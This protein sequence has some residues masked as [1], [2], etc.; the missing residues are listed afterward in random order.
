MCLFAKFTA[1][2]KMHRFLIIRSAFH[3]SGLKTYCFYSCGISYSYFSC[4]TSKC[5]LK[6]SLTYLLIS[7]LAISPHQEIL[8][9]S[10]LFLPSSS[11]C[12]RTTSLHLNTGILYCYLKRPCITRVPDLQV[13]TLL[14]MAT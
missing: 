7:S 12:S 3:L 5:C 10:V 13:C 11:L 4:I 14:Y 2:R 9:F 8:S 6:N 1:L